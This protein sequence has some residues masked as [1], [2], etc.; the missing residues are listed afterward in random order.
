MRRCPHCQA[1]NPSAALFCQRCGQGLPPL[2]REPF[3]AWSD[4]WEPAAL[5]AAL[6]PLL[7]LLAFRLSFGHWLIKGAERIEWHY[8][9][10]HLGHGLLFGLGLAWC[11][12][13]LAERRW[14]RWALVGLGAGLFTEALEYWYTYQHVMQGVA[15]RIWDFF[16]AMNNAALVPYRSLQILRLAGILGPLALLWLFSQPRGGQVL[17]ALLWLGLGLWARALVLGYPVAWGALG[18]ALAWKHLGLYAFSALAG[19]YAL[20]PRQKA[21]TPGPELG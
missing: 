6:A 13:D 8:L 5:R 20:G 16:G 17:A 12:G 3:W 18:T 4:W 14:L 9:A 2:P 21:L 19:L 10:F 15:F 11:R 1:P 7:A